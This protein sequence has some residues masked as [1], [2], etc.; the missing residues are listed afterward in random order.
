MCSRRNKVTDLI[1]PFLPNDTIIHDIDVVSPCQDVKSMGD[2]DACLVC[3]RSPKKT[4]FKDRLSNVC[5]DC[6]QRIVKKNN[7]RIGVRR[8]CQRYTSLVVVY[9]LYA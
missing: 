2:Q 6:T 3:Q 4:F 5:V 9:K 1:R 8:A 7:V